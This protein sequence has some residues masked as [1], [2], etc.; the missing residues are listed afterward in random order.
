VSPPLVHG[1]PGQE[2]LLAVALQQSLAL[3]KAPDTLRD[4]VGQFG[5]LGGSRRPHPAK[6]LDL[7]ID[8]HDIDPIQEQHVGRSCASCA[9]GIRASM[10]IKWRFK[11]SALPK[12]WTALARPCAPRHSCIHAHHQRHRAGACR[13]ASEPGL[14]DQMAGDDPIDDAEHLAHDC[15]T[16]GEQETQRI[17]KA[18]HPLAHRLLGKH[19]ID[20]QRR[21]LGS[22]SCF[23][24]PPASLQSSAIRRAPQ[25]GQKPRRLQLN[26]TRCS[27]WQVSQRTRKKPC[28]KRPHRR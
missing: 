16:A 2:A 3:Q 25:L 11:F 5:E 12:R 1:L 9:R 24:L 15:W 14:L 18:Q 13:L 8:P 19:L 21:A 20:Q 26:A 23:A 27:A 4:R 6:P 10:H 28:S 17:W 22:G 7:S